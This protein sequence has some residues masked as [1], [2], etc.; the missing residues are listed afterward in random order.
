MTPVR[1]P[2]SPVEYIPAGVFGREYTDR[3]QLL[4]NGGADFILAEYVP[5]VSDCVG[6]AQACED[7]DLPLF[8]GIGNLG[9]DGSR[10]DGT[11]IQTLV[12]AIKDYHIDGILAMCTFPPAISRFLPPLRD[13]FP[14]FIGAY[15]HGG[16][17]STPPSANSPKLDPGIPHYSPDGLAEYAHQW[18]EIGAQVIGGVLR[19]R[20]GPHSGPVVCRQ[21]TGE[22]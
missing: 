10:T 16:L 21:V 4:A 22:S 3:A 14:G 2:T 6:V 13:S 12:S 11:P 9:E 8:L 20:P 15:A 18:K 7:I 5:L 1:M 19:D 17:A